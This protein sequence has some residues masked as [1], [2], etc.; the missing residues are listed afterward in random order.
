[1]AGSS[2]GLDE[3]GFLREESGL[4]ERHGRLHG[5]EHPLGK[6]GHQFVTFAREA[7]AVYVLDHRLWHKRKRKKK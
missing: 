4:F 1:M 2:S 7:L 3:D 6:V 5:Q